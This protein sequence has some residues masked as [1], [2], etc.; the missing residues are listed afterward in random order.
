[1]ELKHSDIRKM[2]LDE[3]EALKKN[4]TR[5][6]AT[7]EAVEKND[8]AAIA[9]LPA[10]VND[11]LDGFLKHIDHEERI[12]VPV[13]ENLD[14]WGEVRRDAMQAEHKNQRAWAERL[15]QLDAKADP[16]TAVNEVRGFVGAVL[17]DM[18][19]EER[20]FLNEKVLRDDIIVTD[21]FGG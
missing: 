15:K 12:L 10:E 21:T 9:R 13:L 14:A 19:H 11:V 17:Q 5:V 4:L 7:L 8:A 3:H 20:D 1:M 16:A 2:I 6:S 18:A